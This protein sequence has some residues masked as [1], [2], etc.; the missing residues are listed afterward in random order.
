MTDIDTVE[1][2]FVVPESAADALG[3]TLW[4]LAPNG[5]QIDDSGTLAGRELPDGAVRIA[6]FTTP[7]DAD[8]VA[9]VV[10]AACMRLHIEAGVQRTD[11]P[12]QDWN[13]V[14]K[15][16]YKTVRIGRRIRIDPSWDRL[17]E[18]AGVAAV[19]IDPGQAFGTGTHESTQLAAITLEATLDRLSEGGMDLAGASLLDVGTGS[20]ILALAAVKIGVGSAVGIDSDALA[21]ESA[22]GNLIINGLAERIELRH[23]DDPNDLAPRTFDVVVANIISGVLLQLRSALI[24]RTRSGGRLILSGILTAEHERVV[25]AFGRSGLVLVERVDAGEWTALVWQRTAE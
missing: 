21:L 22:A 17:A 4:R 18:E 20:G 12:R 15:A 9:G 24:D 16:H 25:E 1:L 8:R 19:A 7:G 10:E 23:I 2:A 14:W 5:F 11:I 13:A 6:L 3:P